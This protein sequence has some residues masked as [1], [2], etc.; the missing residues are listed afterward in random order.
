M[1][2]D[3][4][5]AAVHLRRDGNLG[6]ARSTGK[7]GCYGGAGGPACTMLPQAYFRVEMVA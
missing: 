3:H 4:K 1:D 7:R 5:R 6:S 2:I